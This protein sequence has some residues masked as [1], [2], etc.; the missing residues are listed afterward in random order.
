MSNAKG[1]LFSVVHFDGHFQL[2]IAN[3]ATTV[4]IQKV[5]NLDHVDESRLV[6][7]F[8]CFSCNICLF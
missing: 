3:P 7:L 1:E 5:L 4:V 2:D 6:L 8:I